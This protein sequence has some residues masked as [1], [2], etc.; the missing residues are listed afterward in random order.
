MRTRLSSAGILSA[1]ALVLAL[2]LVACAPDLS[3]AE[4]SP[5]RTTTGAASATPRP[6]VTP[7]STPTPTPAPAPSASAAVATD[8]VLR[9][10]GFQVVGDSNAVLF[11]QPWTAGIELAVG[12]LTGAFA[13][14]PERISVDDRGPYGRGTLY[15]WAGFELWALD[16]RPPE[17]AFRVEVSAPQVGPV[18]VRSV[19]GIAVGTSLTS[20]YQLGLLRTGDG[21]TATDPTDPDV[22]DVSLYVGVA[23]DP[24]SETVVRLYSPHTYVGNL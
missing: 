12:A 2:A 10:T 23:V 17:S 22:P 1:I 6:T 4:P 18:A 3:E 7:T 9:P 21:L 24:A 13:G 8:V 16:G 11:E 20:A 5:T 19:E 14:P 15:R